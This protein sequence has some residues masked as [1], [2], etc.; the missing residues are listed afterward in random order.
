METKPAIS[1]FFHNY[2]GDH[3]N[4][5]RFFREKLDMPF[6]LHYNIADGSP[7]T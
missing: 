2:Y 6:D 5:I 3:E 7:T 1:I 4:W